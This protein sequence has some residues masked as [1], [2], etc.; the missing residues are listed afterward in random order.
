M[1][2]PFNWLRIVRVVV[3]L[4]FGL[5]AVLGGLPV[6]F[7][8]GPTSPVS[9]ISA[10]IDDASG[11]LTDSD[12]GGGDVIVE[13]LAEIVDLPAGDTSPPPPAV[14]PP[15][16]PGGAGGVLG[17]GVSSGPDGTST[18][19]VV[20]TATQSPSI[21]TA[22]AASTQTPRPTMTPAVAPTATAPPRPTSTAAVARSTPV[23]VEIRLDDAVLRFLPELRVA[24]SETG[25]PTEILAGVVRVESN[26]DPNLIAAGRGR[27]MT[28]VSEADL[29]AQ[30][31]P[32]D[33]WHDPSTNL[34][35][36]GR[37]LATLFAQTGSW[38]GALE[39]YFGANCDSSGTCSGAYR[40]AVLAWAQYYG[41]AIAS[42]NG[43]GFQLLPASWTAPG[44]APYAGA[45]PRP[46]PLPPGVA[47]P[48]ATPQATATPVATATQPATATVV[49]TPSP[50]MTAVPPTETPTPAPTE[51]ETPTEMPTPV[52][53]EIP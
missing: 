43:G 46:L 34:T 7:G 13:F 12:T 24:A 17:G 41:P 16:P 28:G 9:I 50:T 37:V 38:D 29:S 52:P 8:S 14:N 53:T 33:V 1:T 31:V 47:A 32:M 10:L 4:L 49:P 39:R 20:A 15:E 26:G 44:V 21:A 6:G 19:I 42:P 45:S 18:P 2:N 40:Y 48:T 5:L 51:T 30:G 36:G 35:A 23:T 3:S 22:P 27:G 11:T 25:V